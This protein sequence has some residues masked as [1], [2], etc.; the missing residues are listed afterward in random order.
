MTRQDYLKIARFPLPDD[1]EVSD[2]QCVIVRIPNDQQYLSQ[3]IGLV[4]QLKWSRNFARDDTQTGAAIVSRTWQAALESEPVTVGCGIILRQ[5][6]ANV[7]QLQQSIDGGATWTLAFDYSL[8][9]ES[10]TV[11][12]PYPGSPTGASDAAAA[13]VRNILIGLLTLTPDICAWTRAEYIENATAYMRLFDASYANPTGLGA[14][15]DV[16]C[17]MTGAEQEEFLSECTFWDYKQDAQNCSDADGLFDWLNC[18]NQTIMDWLNNANT[19]IMEALMRAAAALSGN[20]WQTAA[21]GGE[22]GGAGF[23]ADCT[24]TQT[25]NAANGWAG[26]DTLGSNPDLGSLTGGQWVSVDSDVTALVIVSPPLS[27]D[28][29]LTR[30]VFTYTITGAGSPPFGQHRLR[31]AGEGHPLVDWVA[32]PWDAGSQVFDHSQ[33]IGMRQVEFDIEAP[34]GWL[35]VELSEV[36]FYGNGNN[37]YT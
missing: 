9:S 33:G 32:V 23:G 8:C 36:T 35:G 29:S 6:P 16:W 19:D 13:A 7:C 34:L 31:I 2:T 18:L 25:W 24:W 4:D 5:N 3:F 30:V 37:P 12:A 27:R 1:W 11:L 22:G 20:G 14:L 21:A 26:W 15:Y 10:I 28:A 17:G